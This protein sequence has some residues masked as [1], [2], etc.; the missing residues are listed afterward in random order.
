MV[1]SRDHSGFAAAAVVDAAQRREQPLSQD[2]L[3]EPAVAVEMRLHWFPSC[4]L[5]SPEVWDGSG[6]L[7]PDGG[8]D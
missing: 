7:G 8:L 2:W 6:A 5:A 4:E 3:Q 1:G